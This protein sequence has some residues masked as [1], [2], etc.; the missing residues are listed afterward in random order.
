MLLWLTERFCKLQVFND[1]LFK[2]LYMYKFRVFTC[3]CAI[4]TFN[5]SFGNYWACFQYILCIVDKCKHWEYNASVAIDDSV[6]VDVLRLWGDIRRIA[7]YARTLSILS[8][9]A[10]WD[11]ISLISVQRLWVRFFS[12]RIIEICL[13]IIRSNIFCQSDV[14]ILI[15]N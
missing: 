9:A 13:S 10:S 5:P 6:I 12:L 3:F 15:A 11:V 14:W 7:V 8:Q 1:F 2:W 4:L